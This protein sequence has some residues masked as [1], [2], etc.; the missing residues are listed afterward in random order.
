MPAAKMVALHGRIQAENCRGRALDSHKAA[1]A[2]VWALV[3]VAEVIRK[4]IRTIY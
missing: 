3:A 4:P 1:A 2:P